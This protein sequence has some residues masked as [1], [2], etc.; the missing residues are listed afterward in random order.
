[1]VD[2]ND[3]SSPYVRVVERKTG[4]TLARLPK[5]GQTSFV[6]SASFVWA[7]DSTRVA[8][9][10]RA[11]GR[12]LTCGLHQLKAGE[13]VELKSPE[14]AITYGTVEKERR[15]QIKELGLA[16]DVYQRRIWDMWKITG[17]SGPRTALLLVQSIRTVPLP[18][19]D[20]TADLEVWMRGSIQIDDRGQWKLV[21]ARI[22]TDAEIKKEAKHDAM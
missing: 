9:N 13:F 12:Y 11:G 14:E 7:P 2:E 21:K 17:W 4:R 3:E 20:E 1:V 15:K 22:L 16:K 19:E 10:Y 5:E 18:K 6:D 8:H